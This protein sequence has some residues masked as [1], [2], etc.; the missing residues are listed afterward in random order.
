MQFLRYAMCSSMFSLKIFAYSKYHS[1]HSEPR[2]QRIRQVLAYKR[3]KTTG[4]LLNFQAQKGGRGLLQ[5]M[6]VY[7][8]TVRL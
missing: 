2:D 3:L 1:A 4:K 8:T 7:F 6:V 5:Q